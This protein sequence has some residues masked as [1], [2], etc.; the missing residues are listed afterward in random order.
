[1][2]V[3]AYVRV[4]TPDQSTDF[5]VQE[6]TDY[7]A[8]RGWELVET[9][10]DV[11]S[12]KKARRPGLNR[13]MADARRRRFD[14]VVV[15]KMDRFGRSLRDCLNNLDELEGLGVRFIDITQGIDTD[16]SNPA[17]RFLLQILGAAA[18]FERTLIVERSKA[19]L[20]KY[21]KD[22]EAGKVGRSV[23]SRTGKDLPP[24]RPR[25]VF[26]RLEVVRL[27]EEGL[28]LREIAKRMGIGVGTVSRT[29]KEWEG[30]PPGSTDSS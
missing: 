28:S 27:K 8:R 6:I 16:E 18:E 29:L 19:G 11:A 9:Y 30:G 12:G 1:M 17:G 23:H 25:R 26:D 10:S 22:Y 7:V 4:S 14:A 2:R 20:L 5:Q 24:H 3:A 21:K 13:L 15:W